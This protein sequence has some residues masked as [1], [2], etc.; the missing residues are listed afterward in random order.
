MSYKVMLCVNED[1]PLRNNCYR[2]K[3]KGNANYAYND[4]QFSRR[5][6]YPV[7]K[8]FLTMEE[9]RV[10]DGETSRSLQVR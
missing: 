5:D 3:T 10:R 7:C 4:F 8:Y 9:G 6:G 2:F 1:C